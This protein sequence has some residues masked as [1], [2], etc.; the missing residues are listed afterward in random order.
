MDKNNYITSLKDL[1]IISILQ[2]CH[3]I[4]YLSLELGSNVKMFTCATTCGTSYANGK[5]CKD[6]LIFADQDSGEMTVTDVEITMV[7][8]DEVA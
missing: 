4:E 7:N 3:W 5:T 8:G 1:F 6:R 2:Y